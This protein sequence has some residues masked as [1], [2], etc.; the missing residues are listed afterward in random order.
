MNGAFIGGC[1]EVL[2]LISDGRFDAQYSEASLPALPADLARAAQASQ[3]KQR[4]SANSKPGAAQ[5]P[6][7]EVRAAA[8]AL[9]KSDVKKQDVQH[10]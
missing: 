4:Q 10:R 2:A 7:V 3:E 9:A 6:P 1:D 8:E 5:E